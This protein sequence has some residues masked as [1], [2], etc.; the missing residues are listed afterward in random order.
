MLLLNT[1]MLKATSWDLDNAHCTVSGYY[2][3]VHWED[4]HFASITTEPLHGWLAVELYILVHPGGVTPTDSTVT[5]MTSTSFFG[6]L[7]VDHSSTITWLCCIFNCWQ[8]TTHLWK[9]SRL[10]PSLVYGSNLQSQLW[11][12]SLCGWHF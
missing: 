5:A 2:Q 12:S 10:H 7:S 6:S 8:L 3:T 9:N 11:L 1:N 4:R